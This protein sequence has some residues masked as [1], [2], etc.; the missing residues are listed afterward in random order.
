MRARHSQRP[1]ACHTPVAASPVGFAERVDR[2]DE[3]D[4]DEVGRADWL[5]GEGIFTASVSGTALRSMK[6]PG[7]AYNDPILGKDPQPDHMSKYVN[8]TKDNGGVHINSGIPNK[9]FYEL[10]VAL[11]GHAW[12]KAGNI[13]YRTLLD[14]RLKPSAQFQ[15]FANLTADVAGKMYG[16]SEKQAVINAWGHLGITVYDES[17][18]CYGHR[19]KTAWT[20]GWLRVSMATHSAT[21]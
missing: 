13:W 8:T 16:K 17:T 18:Y 3:L 19:T 5:I 4:V 21:S 1:P 6:A 11:G 20:A 10:A 14:S 12:D 2:T 7:T 15:D 9:A